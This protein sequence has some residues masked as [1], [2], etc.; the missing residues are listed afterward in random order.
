M[1]WPVA[2]LKMLPP[3]LLP[4]LFFGLW[5]PVLLPTHVRQPQ[6]NIPLFRSNSSASGSCCRKQL[7]VNFVSALFCVFKQYYLAEV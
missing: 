4:S 1:A 2:M 3:A 5:A 6:A 7:N